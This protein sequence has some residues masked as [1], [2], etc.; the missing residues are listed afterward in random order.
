MYKFRAAQAITFRTTK[1]IYSLCNLL[2][3]RSNDNPNC[4]TLIVTCFAEQ[5]MAL[6]GILQ[7]F[8]FRDPPELLE[9]GSPEL[10]REEC[11]FGLSVVWMDEPTMD[12]AQSVRNR[13][14]QQ[15]QPFADSDFFPI[16]PFTLQRWAEECVV[17]F[18]LNPADPFD[19]DV[20]YEWAL[21]KF[22]ER[23][24]E[25]VRIHVDTVN[26][27][28]FRLLLRTSPSKLMAVAHTMNVPLFDNSLSLIHWLRDEASEAQDKEFHTKLNAASK[29]S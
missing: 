1:V 9:R 5:V 18:R 21:E 27:S 26:W 13:S 3:F 14:A 7:L 17:A 23:D 28:S 15:R 6:R 20:V 2:A 11:S 12:Y 22:D 25:S 10:L 4:A 8:G 24:P 16:S 29:A 19:A